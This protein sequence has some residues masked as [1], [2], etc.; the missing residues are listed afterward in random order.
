MARGL[1]RILNWN[2]FFVLSNVAGSSQ[3]A[4]FCEVPD[5]MHN[6]DKIQRIRWSV[7]YENMWISD[8]SNQPT[9]IDRVFFCT[10]ENIIVFGPP[11]EIEVSL[12]VL[13][14]INI[15][16]CYRGCRT[17]RRLWPC[18]DIFRRYESGHNIFNGIKVRHSLKR[19][20]FNSHFTWHLKV[21][22]GSITR[23]DPVGGKSP[24]ECIGNGIKFVKRCQ[25]NGKDMS[26][27]LNAGYIILKQPKPNEA[28]SDKGQQ[29]SRSRNC[30]VGI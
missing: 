12:S 22:S 2:E 19:H 6:I 14:R 3:L 17:S 21:E 20:T 7:R 16:D 9:K 4:F 18:I 5:I 1:G 15:M 30:G 11:I 29:K 25:A 26:S 23:I 10:G 13:T 24:I 28:S 8:S 27:G